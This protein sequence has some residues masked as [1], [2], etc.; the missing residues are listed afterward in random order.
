MAASGA[1]AIAQSARPTV[2]QILAAYQTA[3]NDSG[4]QS[5]ES[6]GTVAGEGLSGDFHSWRAGLNARDDERLGPR[7]ETTLRLGDRIFLRTSNGNVRELNGYLRRR[8]ITADFVD[9]GAFVK[10]PERSTFLG[11]GSL[12]GKPMWRLEVKADGGEPET[13]WI[14]AQ[15]G[16]PG[17]VEYLDGDGPTTIDLSDWREVGGR[18]FPFRM[19]TSDGERAFDVVQQTTSIVIDGTISPDVF[20]PLRS[21]T[22]AADTVQ[23]VPLLERDSHYACSVS[24]GD[25]RYDFLL[26]TGAQSVLLDSR[27][28]KA[29]GLS[30]L[31]ALEVRGANR[32]GG[33]HVLNLPRI[34]IGTAHLDDLVATSLDLRGAMG[35][36]SHI[37]GILGFPFFASALVELDFVHHTMRF[38][39]PGSFVPRGTRIA[40]DLDR[41]LV[42]AMFRLDGTLDA[43]FIVDTGN[44]GELLLYRPFV[45][46][47]PGIVP[48]SRQA[49]SNYGIGGTAPTY[50]SSLDEL[51]LGGVPLY[52]RVADVVMAEKGAFADRIDAG[53]IGIGI[54]KNFIVTFD[55]S[56]DAL[57]LEKSDAFDDGRLRMAITPS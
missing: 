10:A 43:P 53:N 9:T 20:A 38:G 19:V 34:D 31:G 1:A 44:S 15:S 37:D 33:L 28:A 16:L 56:N 4:V 47:H 40:V 5:F 54:L 39:A 41:G 14:D 13:L 27:V 23:T 55:L 50:R 51:A 35:G 46:A 32:S 3:T 52:H 21:R 12:A 8:A 17:R 49:V 36:V 18:R 29:A 22:I 2:T 57:Y 6:L 7:S 48:F 30:E 24:L 25:K 42:E 45:S 11:F 26:D